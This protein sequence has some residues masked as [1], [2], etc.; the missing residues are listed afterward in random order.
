MGWFG[1]GKYDGDDTQT[2]HLT[3]CEWAKLPVSDDDMFDWLGSKKTKIPK[4]HI[5]LF[6]KNI[7][8]ILSKMN[9]NKLWDEDKAIEWQML[10]CLFL[11]N[12]LKMPKI[13]K[14]NGI[15]ATE[16]LLE[17]HASYFD[18]PSKRRAN[19]RRLLKQVNKI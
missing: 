9:N 12:N 19:L 16:F 5:P 1:Y 4:E 8:L 15:L 7:P 17:E 14:Q 18:E 13:I 10:M 3:Y 2:Q 6:K 11:D